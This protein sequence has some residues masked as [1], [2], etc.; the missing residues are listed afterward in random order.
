MR[1]LGRFP[2]EPQVKKVVL[3]VVKDDSDSKKVPYE[4]F[5]PYMLE[6]LSRDTFLPDNYEMLMKCFQK[7]DK[8]NKGELKISVF[9]NMVKQCE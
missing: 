7:L 8:K 9:K 4:R 5:E 1:Y 6:V 3:E 2:S